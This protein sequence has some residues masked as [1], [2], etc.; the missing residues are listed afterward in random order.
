MALD[1]TKPN[2]RKMFIP[3]LD[4]ILI[5]IDI[6]QGDA[7]V[8]AWEAQAKKLM[9]IFEAQARG[10]LINGYPIDVHSQNALIVSPD[11]PIDKKG[12]VGDAVRQIFKKSVHATNYKVTPYG[13]AHKVGIPI[14]QAQV[15][16]RRW[17]GANPEIP[18]WHEAIEFELM[19]KRSVT[20]IFGYR[21]FFFDRIEDCLP[22]ALAWKPQ[23]T[24]ALTVNAGIRNVKRKIPFVKRLLQVH[25]SALYEVHKSEFSKSLCEDLIDC[26]LI[27]LPYPRPLTMGVDLKCSDI[28]W[29]ECEDM[30]KFL[31]RAA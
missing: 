1:V 13:L 23:S 10:E 4:H 31:A 2:I 3:T 12:R 8:V 22:E 28:S 7:Q 25:D 27:T 6:K 11:L 14:Q 18:K 26:H 30:D 17:F 15:F 16:Q 5:E 29:G 9:A 21:R 19:T 20:N 24:V